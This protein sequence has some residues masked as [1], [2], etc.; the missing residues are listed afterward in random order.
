[1]KVAAFSWFVVS[2]FGFWSPTDSAN[3]HPELDTVSKTTYM[4]NPNRPSLIAEFNA[5]GGDC[6]I[7]T[8]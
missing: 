3:C 1:M 5:M 2:G 7:P 8:C 4:V 6:L